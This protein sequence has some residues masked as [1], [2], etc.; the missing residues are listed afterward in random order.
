MT[1][2]MPMQF[3]I[4]LLLLALALS[5]SFAVTATAADYAGAIS[6]YRRAHGLSAAS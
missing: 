2:L 4:K 3:R 6:T 5:L 1:L